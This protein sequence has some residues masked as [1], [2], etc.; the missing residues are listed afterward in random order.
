MAVYST[1]DKDAFAYTAAD[2]SHLYPEKQQPADSYL[3]MERILS[4]AKLPSKA[5]AIHT[6]FWFFVRKC[7]NSRQMCEQCHIAFHIGP[8]QKEVLRVGWENNTGTARNT[9]IQ[10]QKFPGCSWY[11]RELFIQLIMD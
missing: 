7:K 3:N 4:A 6:G 2:E 11:K 1:A 10:W 8:T 9:M 5:E